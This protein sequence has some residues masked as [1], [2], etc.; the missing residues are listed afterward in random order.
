MKG[1][2]VK[3]YSGKLEIKVLHLTPNKT[4]YAQMEKTT[5]MKNLFK[6]MDL[7]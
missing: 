3:N 2:V 5:Y 6:P 7:I 4:K 1:E